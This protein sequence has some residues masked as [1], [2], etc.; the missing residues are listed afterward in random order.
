MF[1]EVLDSVSTNIQE[2][3]EG[4][5]LIKYRGDYIDFAKIEAKWNIPADQPY[6]LGRRS[7]A[8][9]R[10]GLSDGDTLSFTFIPRTS[11]PTSTIIWSGEVDFSLE[12]DGNQL[13]STSAIFKVENTNL[14]STPV[15]TPTRFQSSW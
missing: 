5:I 14:V 2:N 12:K 9:T 10:E 11:R 13:A 15:P 3:E 8:I 7:T 4:E 1:L 6:Y